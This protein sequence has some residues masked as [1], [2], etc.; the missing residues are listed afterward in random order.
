MLLQREAVTLVA[1][2]V[3]VGIKQL[4]ASSGIDMPAHVLATRAALHR[5]A[6]VALAEAEAR[7]HSDVQAETRRASWNLEEAIGVIEAADILGCSRRQV[8]R[9]ARS[10]NGWGGHQG[11][12][13][14]FHR[15]EVERYA[16][17]RRNQSPTNH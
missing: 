12:P 4:Q 14:K 15:D 7:R 2:L 11:K 10:L 6:A 3:D 17:L 13:W 1:R 9:L 5:A 16:E 8:T